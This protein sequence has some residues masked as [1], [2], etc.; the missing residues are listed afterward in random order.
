M[1]P[2][3]INETIS[4][5]K[6]IFNQIKEKLLKIKNKNE[7]LKYEMEVKNILSLMEEIEVNYF[8]QILVPFTFIPC[9]AFAIAPSSFALMISELIP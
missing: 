1:N 8:L 9:N 3:K 2:N 6:E 5:I 7:K 4:F